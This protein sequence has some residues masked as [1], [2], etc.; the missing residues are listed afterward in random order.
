[1]GRTI[2][3]LAEE[4]DDISNLEA[5]AEEPSESSKASEP[6]Q[7]SDKSSKGKSSEAGVALQQSD[8]KDQEK[9]S[10][11][12]GKNLGGGAP[13]PASSN[14]HASESHGAMFPSVSRLLAENNIKDSSVIKGT[15]VRGMITKGDALA[16]LG[17]TSNPNGS[18][19]PFTGGVSTLGPAAG[20][21]GS[22]AAKVDTAPLTGEQFR[23]L[24]MGGLADASVSA[25][26]KKAASVPA[27]SASPVSFT[28]SAKKGSTNAGFDQLLASYSFGGSAKK[29]SPGPK[30]DPLASLL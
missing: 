28:S 16:Y 13:H 23:S 2:A 29:P 19:K 1:M 9:A 3:L 15:G 21:K 22:G 14:S 7:D 27:P 4:G 17:K 18:F 26:A 25:R 24:I 20:S 12:S 10:A 30:K 11:G 6:E 5:P 8:L